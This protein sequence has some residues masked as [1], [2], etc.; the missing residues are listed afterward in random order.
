MHIRDVS[1]CL[2]ED[3]DDRLDGLRTFIAVQVSGGCPENLE[4]GGHEN[5]VGEVSKC[6]ECQN[7]ECT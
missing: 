1:F 5:V 6:E 2:V 4:A 3:V 7:Y